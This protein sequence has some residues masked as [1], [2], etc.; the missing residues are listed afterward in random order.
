M[1]K[2][3][4]Q[5]KADI[6]DLTEKDSIKNLP[7]A[8]IIFAFKLFDLLDTK[9]KKFSEEIITEIFKKN[10]TKFIVASFATKTL[11]NKPMN[12]PRRIGFEKMLQRNKFT[13]QSF[14]TDNEIFY[15]ISER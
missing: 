10:K 15:V 14:S 3:N 12:L 11:S 4:L 1:K 2:Q 7:Q 9:K 6:F 8:D 13:F 5:G